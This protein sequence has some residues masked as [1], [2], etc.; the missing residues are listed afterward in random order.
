VF[1]SLALGPDPI[2]ASLGLSLAAGVLADAFVVRMIPPAAI[3]PHPTEA[4]IDRIAKFCVGSVDQTVM[5]TVGGGLPRGAR[6]SDESWGARH[7]ILSRLLWLHVPALVLLGLLG[8]MPAWEA[9]AL[10]GVLVVTGAAARLAS[11]RALKAQLTSVGLIAATFVA[12]ELSGGAMAAHIHLY[13]I[14]VFV[15]LYQQ[16]T[17]L[18]WA[19]AVVVVH[20]G[21]YGLLA[22]E[23]V[24]G[25]GSDTREAA[26]MVGV[27]AGLALLEVV[28]IL[29]WWHFAELVEREIEQLA[30]QAE[31]ERRRVELIEQEAA[32]IAAEGERRRA[33]EAVAGAQRLTNDVAEISAEARTALDAVSAVDGELEQLTA[34]VKEVAERSAHAAQ[35][36]STGEDAAR[37]ATERVRNLER[38]VGEIAEVNAL[39]AQLAAQTNLLALNATIEAARAGDLGKGFAVVATEV[40]QLASETTSS[41]DEVSRVIASIVD[42]TSAVATGFASTASTV[43]QIKAL[44]VDIAAAVEEQS[45]VLTEVTRQLSSAARASREI[46]SGLDQLAHAPSN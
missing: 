5:G 44:Q 22:P 35:T 33:A 29:Y 45:A 23:R 14:L 39:I 13:A 19:V 24:F 17:P 38:S 36:A 6:L 18:L 3:E 26:L 25:M 10:P 34:A 30:E 21:V 42:E 1:A 27:H 37:G 11:G 4:H 31:A 9:V 8:P 40:K 41:A 16:W 20:H 46:I 32:Q 12:I 2:V 28:G 43:E 15:A 7:K